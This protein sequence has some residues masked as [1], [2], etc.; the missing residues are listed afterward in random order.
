[1]APYTPQA[2]LRCR[3]LD[4]NW[5]SREHLTTNVAV[6]IEV[7][8]DPELRNRNVISHEYE[9]YKSSQEIYTFVA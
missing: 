9:C 6:G 4:M 7:C 1:M 5:H 3:R 8:G 2:G